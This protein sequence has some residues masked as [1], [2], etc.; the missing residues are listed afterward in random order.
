MDKILVTCARCKQCAVVKSEETV[1]SA[2]PS[3]SLLH[4][5][6]AKCGHQWTIEFRRDQGN[7][8]SP[9]IPLWLQTRCRGN[10]LWAFNENHLDDLEKLVEAKLRSMKP[11]SAYFLPWRLPKWMML[12]KNRDVVLKSIQRL[13]AKL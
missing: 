12:A 11:S 3:R 13:R 8:S 5:S 2:I 10:I 6:C 4:C 7:V 1:R 9:Q